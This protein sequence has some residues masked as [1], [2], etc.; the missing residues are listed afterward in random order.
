ML[1]LSNGLLYR[2]KIKETAPIFDPNVIT[3]EVSGV[4]QSDCVA[5]YD[6]T[7]SS[8][9]FKDNGGLNTISDGENIGRIKNKSTTWMNF[10]VVSLVP[11]S[12][13]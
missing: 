9:I 5:W 13:N 7:D 3:T 11:I 8:S 2:N 4:D 6:F 10:K 1:G 12:D